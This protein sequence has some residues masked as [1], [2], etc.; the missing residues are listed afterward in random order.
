MITNIEQSQ[1]RFKAVK[2][3][4]LYKIRYEMDVKGSDKNKAY[5][6]GIIAYTN[7]E[8]VNTLVNFAKTRVKG[9]KGIRVNELSFEGLCHSMSD[10]VKDAVIKTAIA[11]GK[12]VAMEDHK[13]E[14]V[15]LEKKTPKNTKK[16]VIPKKNKE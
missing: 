7:D 11:E 9:F 16:S 2:G 6:A 13:T 1:E 10:K 5:T 3:I 15:N 8:A 14:L 12:V 4:G